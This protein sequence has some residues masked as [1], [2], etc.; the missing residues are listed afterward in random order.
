MLFFLL[1]LTF[2][3]Q[4]NHRTRGQ[5]RGGGPNNVYMLVNV[6]TIKLKRKKIFTGGPVPVAHTCNPS[7]SGSRDQEDHSLKPAQANNLQDLS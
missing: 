3:L 1:S 6:K 2:S 5:N 4:Q 7:Y